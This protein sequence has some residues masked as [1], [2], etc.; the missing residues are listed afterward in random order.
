MH[1]PAQCQP[2]VW[3]RTACR[4]RQ[5]SFFCVVSFARLPCRD[6][7]MGACVLLIATVAS[8]RP[9]AD[10]DVRVCVLTRPFELAAMLISAALLLIAASV[11]LGQCPPA[12][13]G[14]DVTVC[15]PTVL[16]GNNPVTGPGGVA[17][18]TG[19]WT[20]TGGATFDE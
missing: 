7:A 14:P 17:G 10:A 5:F 9:F 1:S 3:S 6:L 2:W 4:G 13:A 20:A 15:A 19:S 12:T 8:L 11:A 18:G 16:S